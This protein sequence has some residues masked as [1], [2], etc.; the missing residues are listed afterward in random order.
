MNDR[1]SGFWMVVVGL[2][3]I[4]LGY[5]GA[6][7]EAEARPWMISAAGLFIFVFSGMIVWYALDVWVEKKSALMDIATQSRVVREAEAVSRLTPEQA[8]LL[9]KQD[10]GATLAVILDPKG[11]QLRRFFLYTSQGLVPWEFCQEFLTNTSTVVLEPVSRFSNGSAAQKYA[12]W[13]TQW[14][15]ENGFAVGGEGSAAGRAAQW[16]TTDS[17]AAAFKIFDVSLEMDEI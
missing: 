10:F 9:T 4:G 16:L 17:R 6:Q 13:F 2:I 8:A 1:P 3:A 7:M 5:A 14:L 15:R 11:Q 12:Q